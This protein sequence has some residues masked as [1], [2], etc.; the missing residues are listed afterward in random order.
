MRDALEKTMSAINN[1]MLD[2]NQDNDLVCNWLDDDPN[3]IRNMVAYTIKSV[4]ADKV[5]LHFEDEDVIRALGDISHS[6]RA[7][8][9]IQDLC[10]L[11]D[12]EGHGHAH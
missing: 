3:Q 5:R 8:G 6:D 4:E 12:G 9:I 2:Y 7:T 1:L 11:I 10:F